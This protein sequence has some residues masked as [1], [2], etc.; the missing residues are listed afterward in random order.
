MTKTKRK[1][2]RHPPFYSLH[3]EILCTLPVYPRLAL[4]SHLADDFDFP[5]QKKLLACLSFLEREV[6]PLVHASS[7]DGRGVGIDPDY[8]ADA[9]TA[10]EEYW[11]KAYGEEMQP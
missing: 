1:R 2:T 4:L 11:T 7:P 10:A 3:L 9:R 6:C 5:S 8:A